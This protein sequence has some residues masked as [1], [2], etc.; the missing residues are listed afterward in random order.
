MLKGKLPIVIA[1]ALALLASVVAVLAIRQ[2][3][4]EIEEGWQPVDVMIA[5]RDLRAGDTLNRDNIGVGRI[6]KQLVT[7]SVITV[8]D[9]KQG[10]PVFGQK[11][12]VDMSRGDPLLFQHIKTRVGDEKLANA[13]QK[14]GRAL[15]IRV[16]PESSVHHWVEPSDRVDIIGIFRDPASHEM[17]SLTLLQDVIV[18]ATGRIGGQTNRRLLTENDKSYNT[19]TVH[20]Q[21]VAAEMLVLAQEL[22]TLYLTL[23][24]NEDH[25]FVELDDAKTTMATLLNGERSKRISKTQSKMFRVEIIR[26]PQVTK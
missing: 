4:L 10:T 23:R 11:L 18:L 3:G 24:N 19:V 8:K 20:V 5:G 15:S 17:I 7:D 25:D 12:A 16:S 2:K 1:G 26:G 22:G 13:I 21:P 14:N 6:P 9:V